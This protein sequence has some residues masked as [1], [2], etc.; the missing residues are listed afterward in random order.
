MMAR[1]TVGKESSFEITET[2]FAESRRVTGV[3]NGKL[4]VSHQPAPFVCDSGSMCSTSTV[5]L[6]PA[7]DL[8]SW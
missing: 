8:W 5:F 7:S 2:G 6:C 3:S 4:N 1:S